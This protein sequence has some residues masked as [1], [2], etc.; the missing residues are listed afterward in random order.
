MYQTNLEKRSLRS[1]L[2]LGA[3]T[4]AVGLSVPAAA[5]EA[6]PE[7]VVVTGSR[8]PQTGLYS[9]SPVTA[10]GQQE[11]KF[12]GTTNVE[13]LLNNLPSAFADFGQNESNG[14]VG[15]ATVNLRNLGCARTLVLVDGKRLMPGDNELPCA[16]LNQIPAALIDHVDVVTGGASAVYGSDAVAGVVNFIMR[17]DFEGIEFDGQYSVNSHDNSNSEAQ[18]I[19]SLGLGGT[20]PGTVVTPH[21]G[22]WDGDTVDGTI[23]MGANSPNGKGNVTAYAGFRNIQPVTEDKRD[24][25]ACATSTTFSGSFI[26]GGSSTTAANGAGG[27]FVSLNGGACDTTGSCT[28]DGAGNVRGFTTADRFNFAP[29]NYLQRPDTRYTFGAMAHYEVDKALDFYG[30]TM[31]M[32][33]STVAQIA[34]SGLFFGTVA[35]VNCDNPFL[36]SGAD[37]NSPEYNF[38]TSAGLGPTDNASIFA[39]RRNVEG[40]PRQDHLQ[41]A[42]YRVLFGAR[43]DL[44]YGWNYDISGQYGETILSEEY[45]NDMSISRIQHA[46][47]VVRD[48]A[49]GAP[50]CKSVLDGSDPFCV[51]WNIFQPNGVTPAAI[52]YL[53]V[54]GFREGGTREWVGTMSVSG[55]LGAWGIQS[56]WAKNAV[57]IALG[58]EYRQERLENRVDLEFQ[59][60][61]LAGQGG[62]TQS[63]HG[64]YSVSEAFGEIRVPVLQNMPFAEDLT[65][66]A[67]YRYSS[68]ST[69]GAV[70]SY[71]YGA[72]WQPIDDF[73]LRASFQRAV[74][75]PNV[76][77]LFTPQGIGLAAGVHDL[78]AGANPILSLTQCE[79]T[80]VTAAEYGNI[81]DC[82]AAQCNALF[83]GNLNLKPESSDTREVGLVLT[84]T[85]LDGFTA[86]VDYFN[87]RLTGAIG[88][89]PWATIFQQCAVT[90]APGFC[91][92]IHRGPQ[93]VLFG[94]GA[95][96]GFITN[97]N[98]NTGALQTRGMDF[99]ANYVSDL[100]NWGMGDNGSLAFNFLGTWTKDYQNTPYPGAHTYNCAGLFGITCGTPIP[101][102]RHKLRVTWTSPWD[103][104]FSLAWRHM[105]SVNFDGN[106]LDPTLSGNCTGVPGTPC[107]DKSDA[108][109]GSYDYLDL[110]VNWTV[111]EGV[112]LHAGVNNVLD[113]DP[114]IL[115]TNYLGV[116]SP[117][118][119]N[120]NTYP[121]VY[122]AL[123]RYVFVGATIKY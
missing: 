17:R 93:G 44:G 120:A 104:D 19:D 58:S 15:T 86:T 77:E 70:H 122:D 21:G 96:V 30:S 46:L 75:A 54:P 121:Q 85:F 60:G 20:T 1:A 78:C 111:Y 69:A 94:S 64:G 112:Q 106:T 68:Y 99:E 56:P 5:Q 41:H 90:G 13:N 16:D 71:K 109:I 50:V 47:Q 95:G 119:G 72:E 57:G 52:K 35:Q 51:P 4:A 67:G 8:I 48:P 43:G 81:I 117:P 24:F 80:G 28:I 100:S 107:G 42:A 110:A 36:G 118:F 113:K 49:T 14:S 102:W 84:P 32:D 76:L 82:P 37:P 74:R 33:D 31:F 63:V 3:A 45:T 62:P 116:S 98:L 55:D 88:T 2:L 101:E 97:T 18:H 27:R 92:L 34:P 38:C 23:I 61:D 59:T 105:S 83:G 103:F 22:T 9:S 79:N 29:Y 66:N 26:C 89:I 91:S 39:G 25:S 123:G 53:D 6:A 12:E 7:T 10:V 65:L 40:G 73:R 114:P 11:M 115:D 87:I 108:T